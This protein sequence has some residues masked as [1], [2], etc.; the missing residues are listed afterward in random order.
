MVRVIKGYEYSA[1]CEEKTVTNQVIRGAFKAEEVF[2]ALTLAV[3]A[4][5]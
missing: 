5:G 3:W 1:Y 2:P 4:M